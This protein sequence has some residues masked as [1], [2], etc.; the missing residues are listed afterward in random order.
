MNDEEI[1]VLYEAPIIFTKDV[2]WESDV[3]LKP[4]A[5]VRLPKDAVLYVPPVTIEQRSNTANW[6]VDYIPVNE[7]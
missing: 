2:E 3:V 4:G 7:N 1:T 6:I 5:I